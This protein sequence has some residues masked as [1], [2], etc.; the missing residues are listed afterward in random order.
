MPFVHELLKYRSVAV[1][2]M[3]KNCGKTECLNY[4]LRNLPSDGPG[5]CVTSI[6]LDGERTD[7]VTGTAKPEIVLRSGMFFSTSETHYRSRRL[8]SEIVDVSGETTALGRLITARVALEGKVILSGP[9]STV[10]LKRWMDS[11]S[12]FGIGLTIIDGALSRKSSA[13]PAVSEAMVLATGAALSCSMPALVDRT[14][15][16]VEMIRLPEVEEQKIP[17]EQTLTVSSMAQ[18]VELAP[19]VR[20]IEVSGALT[21]RLLARLLTERRLPEIEVTVADFTR[22]F[23]SPDSW[24]RFVRAGG[25]LRVH[26]RTAL[27]A[28]CVN[29]LAPN[30]YRLDSDLL[31]RTLSDRIQLP[32][33]DIRRQRED[34]A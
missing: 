30:G 6:G 18:E 17:E 29:P 34:E 8:V 9:S 3:E 28:V 21:D 24:R 25:R 12:G 2:G 27:L 10:S 13:S 23:I 1:V 11:I 31:C 22:I 16:C 32:V 4:I 7:Q 19:E 15:F 5:V 14:A 33:Y 20:R 26:R